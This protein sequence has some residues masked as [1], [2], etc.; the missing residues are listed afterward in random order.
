MEA[1]LWFLIADPSSSPFNTVIRL[2]SELKSVVE[3]GGEEEGA[4][5]TSLVSSFLRVLKKYDCGRG[6]FLHF[7]LDSGFR[8]REFT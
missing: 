3:G 4:I 1:F 2:D 7:L 6:G 8:S 5:S